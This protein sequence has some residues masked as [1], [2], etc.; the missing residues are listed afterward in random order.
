MRRSSQAVQ[1][2]LLLLPVLLLLLLPAACQQT[3]PFPGNGE[4]P[5]EPVTVFVSS[6]VDRLMEID[7]KAYEFQVN[8]QDAQLPACHA[9][10]TLPVP[11]T[12]RGTS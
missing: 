2:M 6:Y 3:M 5:D 12:S 9:S 11:S 10:S 8:S 7:D 1:A 4:E